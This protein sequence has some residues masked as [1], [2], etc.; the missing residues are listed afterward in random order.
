[1]KDIFYFFFGWLIGSGSGD[2]VLERVT[3]IP[4]AAANLTVDA[5]QEIVSTPW[6]FIPVI[7]MLIGVG[8]SVFSR[9]LVDDKAEQK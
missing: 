8:I 2:E 9:F 5:T 3:A 4:D 6:L 7:L 1:M